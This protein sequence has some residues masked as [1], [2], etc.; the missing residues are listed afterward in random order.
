MNINFLLGEHQNAFPS[1]LFRQQEY[2]L[3]PIRCVRVKTSESYC[4]LLRA[5]N[6][7]Y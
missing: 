5:G 7:T 4:Y 2:S 3:L 1:S 6:S